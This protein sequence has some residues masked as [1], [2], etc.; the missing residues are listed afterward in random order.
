MKSIFV[1]TMSEFLLDDKII[2]KARFSCIGNLA[3]LDFYQ[4]YF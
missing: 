3:F 1:I 2:I 4:N